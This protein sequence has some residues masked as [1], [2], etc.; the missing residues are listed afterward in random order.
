MAQVVKPLPQPTPETQPFWDSCR[1]HEMKLPRCQDCGRF[2]F[3]PRAMCPHCWSPN[4]EWVK[5]SGQGNLHSYII[6]HR[7]APGFEDD[8][9]YVIA[10]VELEE[11]VRM[12]SNLVG[13]EPDPS[14][15]S[16]DMALQISYEDVSDQITMP[17]FRPA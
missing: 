10:I 12:M 6:N 4:L 16:L 7:P 5:T 17:K 3:Y 13:V 9:P 14:M 1:N 11:G 2:H 8:T 15:L